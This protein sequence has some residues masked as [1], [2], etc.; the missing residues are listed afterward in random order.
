M[1]LTQGIGEMKQKVSKDKFGLEFHW[2]LDGTIEA[3]D[4]CPPLLLQGYTFLN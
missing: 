4:V 3:T 2:R 1:F